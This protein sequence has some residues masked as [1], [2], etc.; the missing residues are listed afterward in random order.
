M[1]S[2]AYDWHNYG[3]STIGNRSDIENVRDR[4]PAGVLPHVLPAR[5]RGAAGRR[6]V[7][8]E[9]GARA[10]RASTSA[11]IPKPDAHAAACSGPSSPRR[12]ASASS[13]CAARATSRSWRSPTRCP[14]ACTTIRDAVGFASFVLGH[15]PTGRLHKAL[16]ET[17]KAAQVFGL[18]LN[19]RYPG[20]Q[21]FG[22]VVKKGDPVEPVRDELI[23]LVEGFGDNPP[24]AEEMERTEGLVPEP[25]REDARQPRVDRRADVGVHRAR[26]LAAL[27]PRARRRREGDL[28][29]RSPRRRRPYFRR[30]NRTVG[31]FCPRTIRSAPRSPRRPPVAEVMK[32]FK[33]NDGTT[34]V[35]EPSIPRRPTSTR[36]PSGT[37]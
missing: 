25:G 8:R 1:Q 23:K 7:R 12:T 24:T 6:Q 19:G 30:D 4:E 16:V 2:V 36:A 35:A 18:P 27:L 13:R 17:G 34:S 10:G 33:G 3:R 28:G 26:R 32:D 21:L 37:R 20:L 9:E 5:Q 11:P 31:F 22:A 29:D 14:R 15:V